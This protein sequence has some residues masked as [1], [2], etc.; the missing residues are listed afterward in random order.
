MKGSPVR[1]RTPAWGSDPLGIVTARIDGCTYGSNEALTSLQR[2]QAFNRWSA[3]VG[4]HRCQASQ[5][6][7]SLTILA[8]RSSRPCA[9]SAPSCATATSSSSSTT[10]PADG[11]AEA[12]RELAPEA[13]VI[14]TGANLGFA[15][16]CNQGARAAGG[17]L[18]CLLNPDAVP[19]P[20]W[21][22][23]IERPAHR[24][25]R[26]GCLAGPRHLRRRHRGQHPRRRRSLHRHRL[27]RWRG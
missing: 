8:L 2:R 18:L 1:I 22:D 7:S 12:V 27:G 23:A 9:R 13:I 6:S 3:S 5:S 15:A 10:P 24:G 11:S 19:A 4:A 21:R 25:A 26:L 14:E 16:A 20:G 17:E